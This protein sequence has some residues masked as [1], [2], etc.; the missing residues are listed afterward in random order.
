MARITS[1]STGELMSSIERVRRLSNRMSRELQQQLGM[2]IYQVGMLAAVEDGARHLHQVADA[3]GQ[4][5]S[6]A[7]RLVERLVKEGL[8]QRHSDDEDRRAVV[9]AL[10]PAGNRQLAA[11]RQL[12]GS[13]VRQAL[14]RMPGDKA[15]ELLPV[16]GSFLEAAET[17][18]DDNAEGGSRN[19]AGNC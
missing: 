6:G 3:T 1:T 12:L 8:L 13:V 10:T 11:A 18:L 16:L 2:S 7:S 4:H 19:A 15:G 9:L 5:V 17:V 14:E